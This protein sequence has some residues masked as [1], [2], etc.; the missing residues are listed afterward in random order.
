LRNHRGSADQG[1]GN[2]GEQQL[3]HHH[4]LSVLYA[5]R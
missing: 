1:S 4:G 3:F 5:E 2:P